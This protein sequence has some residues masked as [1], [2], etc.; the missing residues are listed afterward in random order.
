MR[1]HLVRWFFRSLL[2]GTLLTLLFTLALRPSA[3]Q[4][5]APLLTIPDRLPAD[6]GTTVTVPI[7]LTSGG[8]TLAGVSFSLDYDQQ[9]LA[10]DPT[11]ANSD[12]VPDTVTFAPSLSVFSVRSATFNA[13]D[14]TGELDVIIA[15]TTLP[16]DTLP[17][18]IL[19]S[20]TLQVHTIATLVET[21]IRFSLPSPPSFSDS[22]GQAVAGRSDSGSVVINGPLLRLPSDLFAPLGTSVTIPLTLATRGQAVAGL[23]FSLDYDQTRL[24]FDP[25]DANRDGL[26]DAIQFAPALTPFGFR[27]VTFDSTR[28]TRELDIL[29]ADTAPPL[30][31]L[32]DGVIISITFHVDLSAPAGRAMVRFSQTPPVAFANLQGASLPGSALDGSILVSTDLPTSTPTATSTPTVT[33]YWIYLSTIKRT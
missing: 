31:A 17:D 9:T 23:N 21:P 24:S 26:P 30:D 13:T 11:D 28:I 16:F 5:T 6:P 7:Q 4:T 15:D 19:I 18:G 32:A 12:G 33:I 8:N 2:W 1:S 10:F 22:Q 27:S 29:L 3:A 14:S 25:T 20:V